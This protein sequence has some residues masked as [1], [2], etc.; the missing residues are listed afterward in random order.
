MR[1]RIATWNINSVRLRFSL[2]ERFVAEHQPDILCL[3]ETK[4]R[5][6]LFPR[7]AFAALGYLH[8]EIRGQSGYNGVATLSRLPL[9]RLGDESFCG[10]EAARHLGVAVSPRPGGQAFA[11]HNIYVPAGGDVPD[12]EANPKFAQKLTYLRTLAGWCAPFQ[13]GMPAVLTGD[14]N[15]A[16]LETDVWSHKQLLS[17]VSHTPIEVE[18]LGAVQHAGGWTDLVR[19][20]VP[21]DRKLY[22]W[23]SYR[24]RDWAASDR[25]RRLDHIWSSA[26]MAEMATGVQVL[27]DAR[28]WPQPSDHV[29]VIADFEFPA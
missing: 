7:D 21:P 16:P 27:K 26:R 28:G 22:S 19:K 2:V 20:F 10:T 11:L 12:P 17:V 18:R 25:G 14:F 13:A 6:D 29:P 8:Q 23:W 3:Q 9:S 5:D 24:A 4:C 15:V 1:V